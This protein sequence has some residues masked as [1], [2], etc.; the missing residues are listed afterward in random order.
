MVFAAADVP[1]AAVVLTAVGV[2]AV[3]NIPS[4]YSV[5]TSWSL[6]LDVPFVSARMLLSALLLLFCSSLC[7]KGV[8]VCFNSIY[9]YTS[10]LR[11][12]FLFF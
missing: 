1:T 5:S 12:I 8:L 9:E 3:V 10:R 11:K 6:S 7:Q 2:L 4:V